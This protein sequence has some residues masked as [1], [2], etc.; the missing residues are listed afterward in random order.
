MATGPSGVATSAVTARTHRPVSSRRLAAVASST[1]VRRAAR[2]RSAPSA[3]RRLR[4]LAA[5]A[6]TPAG[7]DGDATR[8]PEIHA[9]DRIQ[10]LSPSSVP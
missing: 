5:D 2:T 9:G 3:A 8:Q 10:V 4:D 7:D 1:S 6:L